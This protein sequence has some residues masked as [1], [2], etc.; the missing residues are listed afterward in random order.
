L[1]AVGQPAAA[2]NL[3]Q[4]I[5]FSRR[6]RSAPLAIL[7]PIMLKFV[8]LGVNLQKGKVIREGLH[9]YRNIMLNI[10]VN[11]IET[12]I[13]NLIRDA[14][15]KVK[16]A[17]NIVDAINLDTVEDLEALETPES[18]MLSTVSAEYKDRK[19]K[20]VVTPW[21]KFLWETYRIALDAL[22][23]NTKLEVLY[24]QIGVEAFGF[25]L[26]YGRKTEFKRLSELLRQHLAN[27]S[28]HSNQT[29]GINLNDLETL[30]RYLDMRFVQL[31]AATQLE[32]W[33]EAFRTTEDIQSLLSA[34]NRPSQ[35][36]MVASYYENLARTFMVGEN[37]LFHAAAWNKYY[38]TVQKNKNLTH[39]ELEK[40]ASL[41]LISALAVPLGIEKSQS[42]NPFL[43]QVDKGRDK[44]F[45]SL[46]R[47][48]KLPTREQLVREAVF[49]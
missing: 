23:N 8:S 25:C 6:H 5:I 1:I 10:S 4:D 11:T 38:E 3:L 18:L 7:E 20:E 19:D 24:Q 16:E 48:E 32:L 21:V 44:R 47:A 14:A 2:F 13:K 22:R 9:T 26:K 46:L 35:A 43:Y 15:A 42:D 49:T 12:V 17:Q 33:Q 41:V 28:K 40:I 39:E 34:S 29:F 27:A 36:F 45:I 30:Q 37:Y 31:N